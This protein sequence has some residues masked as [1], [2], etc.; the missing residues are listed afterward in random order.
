MTTRIREE[1][2]CV[3]RADGISF[4]SKH[5]E[6]RRDVALQRNRDRRTAEISVC[7]GGAYIRVNLIGFAAPVGV[8]EAH[9]VKGGVV[10]RR[11][12]GV[13]NWLQVSEN[14]EPLFWE[15]ANQVQG[16][17]DLDEGQLA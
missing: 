2:H 15:L 8:Q 9:M 10:Q 13:C 6:L 7:K 11:G 1:D 17:L 5:V 16:L 12:H 4:G 3:D 14:V